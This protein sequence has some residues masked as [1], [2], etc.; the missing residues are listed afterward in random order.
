MCFMDNVD[1][2]S[3]VRSTV[4]FRLEQRQDDE[5]HCVE[6]KLIMILCILPTIVPTLEAYHIQHVMQSKGFR[7]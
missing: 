7:K 2:C 1:V 5:K 4:P 3:S 6:A